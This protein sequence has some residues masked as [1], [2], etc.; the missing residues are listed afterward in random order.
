MIDL[1]KLEKTL[2]KG[3]PIFGE[4]E[5]E[6]L[7]IYKDFGDG[8]GILTDGQNTYFAYNGFKSVGDICPQDSRLINEIETTILEESKVIIEEVQE[9]KTVNP[10]VTKKEVFDKFKSIIKLSKQGIE[11]SE[12]NE[13][14]E[15]IKK[16]KKSLEDSEIEMTSENRLFD[17]PPFPPFKNKKTNKE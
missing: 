5:Q 10:T 3:A 15:N 2:H 17:S 11:M 8:S 7:Y 16:Y 12:L 14:E 1:T 9:Y 6:D 4:K 13:Y